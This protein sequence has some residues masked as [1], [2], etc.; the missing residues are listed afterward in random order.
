MASR[1]HWSPPL[2]L[3][4]N[5]CMGVTALARVFSARKRCSCK[6]EGG[7]RGHRTLALECT[8]WLTSL[9]GMWNSIQTTL[10]LVLNFWHTSPSWRFLFV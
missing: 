5:S 6:R 7:G 3:S 2:M 4:L 10:G 8:S 9:S 1:W